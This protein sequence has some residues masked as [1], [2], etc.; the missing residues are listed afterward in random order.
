MRS[1]SPDCAAMIS[2]SRLAS[3]D[4]GISTNRKRKGNDPF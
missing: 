4:G 2:M 3:R 1:H